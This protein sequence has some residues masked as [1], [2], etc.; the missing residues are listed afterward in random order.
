[1]RNIN[2]LK[3]TSSYARETLGVL[4]N[5]LKQEKA[6]FDNV[7]KKIGELDKGISDLESSFSKIN[8]NDLP[9]EIANSII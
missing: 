7:Y 8:V 3:E 4:Y 1:M 5:I 2:S 9:A 6:E